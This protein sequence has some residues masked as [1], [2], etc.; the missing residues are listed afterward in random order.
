MAPALPCLPVQTA[1]HGAS[2]PPGQPEP[3]PHTIFFQISAISLPWFCF[4]F[5]GERLRLPQGL[6]PRITLQEENLVLGLL[7]LAL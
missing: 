1:D 5:S 6:L 4:G 3:S 7:E 2:Q